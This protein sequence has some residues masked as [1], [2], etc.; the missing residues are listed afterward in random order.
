MATLPLQDKISQ[1]SNKETEYRTLVTNFGGGYTQRAADGINFRREKWSLIFEG[2]DA[3][4]RQTLRDFFD[5][6]GAHITFDWQPPN[7]P[8]TKK[9]RV[10]SRV[11]E[12]VFAGDIFNMSVDVIEE[13]DL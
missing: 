5:G 12:Q 9:W 10:K 7:S 2:L 8:S 1:N 3:T 4:E 11:K 6:L 13:F